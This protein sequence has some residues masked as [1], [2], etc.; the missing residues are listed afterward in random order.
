MPHRVWVD[1]GNFRWFRDR[2]QIKAV[3]LTS[4]TFFR[5]Q[6]LLIELINVVDIDVTIPAHFS[7]VVIDSWT[8]WRGVAHV[9]LEEALVLLGEG[10]Q[11][12][13]P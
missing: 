11:R 2:K 6:T 13:K 1:R 8:Q 12:I 5:K 7:S 10:F 4:P 9:P 3:Q